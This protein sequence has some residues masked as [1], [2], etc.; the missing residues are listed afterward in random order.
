MRI[1]HVRRWGG[2]FV[3][4]DLCGTC[5]YAFRVEVLHSSRTNIRQNEGDLLVLRLRTIYKATFG[6][7]LS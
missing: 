6:A 5:T 2:N 4:A 1:V 3:D 7:D